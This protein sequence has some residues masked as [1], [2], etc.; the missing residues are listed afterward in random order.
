M[1]WRVQPSGFGDPAASLSPAGI[2]HRR[3]DSSSAVGRSTAN[4][5]AT[6]Y[7]PVRIEPGDIGT[8]R[9]EIFRNHSPI[10]RV[11]NPLTRRSGV[12]V[13]VW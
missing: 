7:G 1:L 6:N 10:A 3:P 13:G 11:T 2:F 4:P 9:R 8:G 5:Q 12:W